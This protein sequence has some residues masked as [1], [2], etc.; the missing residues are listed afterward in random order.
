MRSGCREKSIRASILTSKTKFFEDHIETMWVFFIFKTLEKKIP[1]SHVANLA[2]ATSPR[3]PLFPQRL[4]S[5]RWED[6]LSLMIP[7]TCECDERD[8][9]GEL[10][11]SL[12]FLLMSIV[13]NMWFLYQNY[14]YNIQLIYCENP[15]DVRFIFS[16]MFLTHAC[17][18]QV[19]ILRWSCM[20]IWRHNTNETW[21]GHPWNAPWVSHYSKRVLAA[22]V[23]SSQAKPSF[24][25][26]VVL[27]TI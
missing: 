5:D 19:W 9:L 22:E 24:S 14:C 4:V 17:D 25:S 15:S 27:C 10:Q 23:W 6:N 1:N 7:Q 20:L 8:S 21:R 18:V 16:T 3:T 11:E 2:L 13:S 12:H 26:F